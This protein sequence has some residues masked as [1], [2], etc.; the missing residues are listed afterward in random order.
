MLS[1]PQ[2]LVAG[3]VT[4]GSAAWV[5]P[6]RIEP[7][8]ALTVAGLL[9]DREPAAVSAVVEGR[10]SGGRS[11]PV[12]VAIALTG[13]ALL[14]AGWGGLHEHRVDASPLAHL[15]P[16]HVDALGT[17]RADPGSGRFGWTAVVDLS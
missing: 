15:A 10:S 17:L 14:A 11:P 2:L 4:L 7:P 9:A 3:V 16:M 1:V 12:V 8:G 13:L 5:S 6:R